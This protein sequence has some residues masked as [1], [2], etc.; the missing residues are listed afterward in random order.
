MKKLLTN[1]DKAVI[2][3]VV[4]FYVNR[5]WEVD[6]HGIGYAPDASWFNICILKSQEIM[7]DFINCQLVIF[8]YILHS[9]GLQSYLQRLSLDFSYQRELRPQVCLR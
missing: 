8:R 6:G 1:G 4:A 7:V 5:K 9:H 3:L 2:I